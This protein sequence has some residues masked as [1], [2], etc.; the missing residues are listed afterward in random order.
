MLNLQGHTAA[1]PPPAAQSAS[2]C[3]SQKRA[4]LEAKVTFT[5]VLVLN[6]AACHKDVWRSGGTACYLLARFLVRTAMLTVVTFATS[7]PPVHDVGHKDGYWQLLRNDGQLCSNQ[8][9][10]YSNLS[11]TRCQASAAVYRRSSLF[12]VA[13][14]RVLVV[15]KLP[16]IYSA[17]TTQQSEDLNFPL[18]IISVPKPSLCWTDSS[19]G[20]QHWAVFWRQQ[21]QWLPKLHSFWISL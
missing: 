18:V 8:V 5:A 12:C 10:C 21:G 6:S 13:M 11:T 14:Q 17:L 4:F 19:L 2:S 16:P 1:G 7:W 20:K 3:W 9:T 15:P